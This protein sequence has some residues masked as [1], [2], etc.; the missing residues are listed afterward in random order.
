MSAKITTTGREGGGRLFLLFHSVTELIVEDCEVPARL[1]SK[2]EE[3]KI[4]FTPYE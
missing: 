4:A 1:K 2:G 3:S